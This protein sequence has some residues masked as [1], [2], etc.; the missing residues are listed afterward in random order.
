MRQHR[1][2]VLGAIAS[3][4]VVVAT[5]MLRH[6]RAPSITLRYSKSLGPNSY[7][8]WVTNHTANELAIVLFTIQVRTGSVWSNY[9]TVH[10]SLRFM[11]KTAPVPIPCL[12]PHIAASSTVDLPI[13]APA[14]S[15]RVKALVTERLGGVEEF[16]AKIIRYRQMM[17]VRRA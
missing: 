4:I 9:S 5:L 14:C 11:T 1:K 6:P 10:E 16:I 8:F 2:L 15:W 7:I 12:A 3:L 17:E 13:P